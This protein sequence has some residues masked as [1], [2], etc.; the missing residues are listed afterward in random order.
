MKKV[1]WGEDVEGDAGGSRRRRCGQ[2]TGV[3]Q[4]RKMHKSNKA[5][6]G[7]TKHRQRELYKSHK[8]QVKAEQARLHINTLS[9]ARVKAISVSKHQDIYV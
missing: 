9:R 8:P 7:V 4:A 6:D 2:T 1:R 5:Q 3:Y